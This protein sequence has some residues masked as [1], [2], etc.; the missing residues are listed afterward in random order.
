MT[1]ETKYPSQFPKTNKIGKKHL[2][3]FLC[4][5]RKSF[6]KTCFNYYPRCPGKFRK[7][8]KK[9]Y[10]FGNDSL[11][12]TLLHCK[13]PYLILPS[14]TM[15]NTIILLGFRL[16]YRNKLPNTVGFRPKP[17][18]CRQAIRIKQENPKTLPANQYR[19]LQRRNNTGEFSAFGGP[20]LA[21]SSSR[22]SIQS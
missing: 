19:V 6:E 11:R 21:P 15:P 13:T 2:L 20:F 7:L 17:E 5:N 18:N 14:N 4:N 8:S 22:L 12:L 10:S 16:C 3:V 9:S 1:Y